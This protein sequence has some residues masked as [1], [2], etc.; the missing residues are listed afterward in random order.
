MA[1]GRQQD[2]EALAELFDN[3]AVRERGGTL[4]RLVTEQI[5]T[6]IRERRLVEGDQLPNERELCRQFGVS[7]TVVREAIARLSAKNLLQVRGGAGG[8]ISVRSPSP[9]HVSD[10]LSLLLHMDGSAGAHEKVL[11]VRRL[12]EV[13][14]AG[15]A[16]ERRSAADLDKLASNLAAHEAMYAAV[17]TAAHTTA[18]HTLAQEVA[19][20]GRERFAQLDLDFHTAIAAAT[21]NDLF[22]ILLDSLR[23][24]LLSLRRLGYSTPGNPQRA[25]RHHR[26]IFAAIQAG[27]VTAARKAMQSHLVEAEETVHLALALQRQG[28]TEASSQST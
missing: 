18:A 26:A 3:M 25:L 28:Q 13:E 10:T 15:L 19:S 20:E 5:E 14:I 23:D 24:I 8:G 6:M 11:E 27:N 7:R 9:A 21:Q 22:V 1:N 12:L 16:A 2:N 4:V 17:Q